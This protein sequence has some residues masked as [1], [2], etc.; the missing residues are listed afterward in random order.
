L[1]R[2]E[3]EGFAPLA[4]AFAERDALRGLRVNISNGQTGLADGVDASGALR[5]VTDTGPLVLT[6]HEVSVRPC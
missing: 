4:A 5:L 1:L 6:Q 3:R 2:F